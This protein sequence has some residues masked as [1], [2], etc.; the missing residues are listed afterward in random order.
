MI[1]TACGYVR[2]E[3]PTGMRNKAQ[4]VDWRVADNVFL[5]VIFLIS[6][7]FQIIVLHFYA[8]FCIW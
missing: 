7:V 1:E 8:F 3:N 6:E 4:S 2:G 5:L